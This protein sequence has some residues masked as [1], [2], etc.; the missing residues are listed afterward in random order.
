MPP[1]TTDATTS[2]GDAIMAIADRLSARVQALR[3]AAPVTHVYNPLDYA[4]EAVSDYAHK[5]GQ[6][7][8]LA[9]LLGMNPGPYG[10]AQT[11]VPFGEVAAVRDWLGVRGHIGRPASEHPERPIEGFACRRSEVSGARLWGFLRQEFGRPE[12]FFEHAFVWN[13]CPLL[14]SR[15]EHS[16]GRR[17]CRNLTPDALPAGQT[18]ELYAACD[19]AL[20]DLVQL[21]RPT[22]L[23]GVG[24]FAHRRLRHLF[25]DSGRYRIGLMLHPSPASPL[26]NRDFAGT[27]RR[28]L[29]E[30]GLWP[31]LRPG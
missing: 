5:Y 4:R 3:F 1:Q 28:Q 6:A 17:S 21:L 20:L 10:M 24:G 12:S 29:T 14:F 7:P 22:Y 8:K 15:I 26:A 18:R 31:L 9:L 13:Y 2:S 19:D 27:A 11:G 23:V 16:G 30:L 25:E